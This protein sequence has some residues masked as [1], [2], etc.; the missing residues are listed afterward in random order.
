MSPKA[1]KK[2]HIQSTWILLN[3]ALAPSCWVPVR[4]GWQFLQNKEQYE[5]NVGAI[6]QKG[7]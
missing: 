4:G 6:I 2:K 7:N 3:G 5:A 1:A